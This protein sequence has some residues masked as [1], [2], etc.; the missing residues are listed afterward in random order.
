[1]DQIANEE[2]TGKDINIKIKNDG[3]LASVLDGIHTS[4][5]ANSPHM[6]EKGIAELNS[7][8]L[9][10]VGTESITDHTIL[11]EK[12]RSHSPFTENHISNTRFGQM[13][14]PGVDQDENSCRRGIEQHRKNNEKEKLELN[15]VEV[16]GDSTTSL[17]IVCH[18]H[19]AALGENQDRNFLG[20][21]TDNSLKT[22]E[23]SKSV[24]P[25]LKDCKSKDEIRNISG[26]EL[27][28]GVFIDTT[29]P[30]DAEITSQC[31][32]S[33]QTDINKGEM[34]SNYDENEVRKIEKATATDIK[35]P[36]SVVDSDVSD[37]MLDIA[38]SM[39]DEL[40][41]NC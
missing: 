2:T 37:E 7:D 28:N 10:E 16:H 18:K 13:D 12:Q 33:Y 22:D 1:M 25:K 35:E 17:S 26:N 5:T 39:K 34:I 4:N 21:G 40:Q 8:D 36:C 23:K 24:Q 14:I 11:D 3:K 32:V 20:E 19:A 15:F 6:D 29:I 30:Y 38:T 9:L 27:Q 41:M 31:F